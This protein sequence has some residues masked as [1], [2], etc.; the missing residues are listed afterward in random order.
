MRSKARLSNTLAADA[1]G[2]GWGPTHQENHPHVSKIRLQV[3]FGKVMMAK[4]SLHT[5]ACRVWAWIYEPAS[6]IYD[7]DK[8]GS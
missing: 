6:Q 3:K 8:A 1:Q 7:N 2:G 5:Y 4:G